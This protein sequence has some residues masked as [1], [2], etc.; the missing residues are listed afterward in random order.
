V[1]IT[2][3]TG[4]GKNVVAKAIHYKCKNS[5]SPLLSLNCASLSETM[6]EAELFGYEKGAFTGAT[7]A[8]KGVFELAENG[9]LFLDEIGAMSI[10]LQSKLLGVLDEGK[11]KR[12]G[13]QSFLEVNPRIIAATNVDL[14]KH[15]KEGSFRK[16]LYYR[17]CV[18]KIELPPLR[19]RIEDIPDLCHFFIRR[20]TGDKNPTISDTEIKHLMKYPWPGNIRELKNIIERSIILHGTHLNPSHLLGAIETKAAAPGEASIPDDEPIQSLKQVEVA[21]IKK[22]LDYFL[23]NY[24]KSARALGISLSTLKRKLKDMAHQNGSK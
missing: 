15:M 11:V 6:I 17:L 18:M 10:T 14:E 7:T 2:G 24:T 22:V 23:G 5:D 12:I 9:T 20:F 16:D 21:H 8:R 3:E 4:T 1:L 13:G 19:H